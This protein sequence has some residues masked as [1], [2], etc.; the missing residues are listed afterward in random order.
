MINDRY[1][2]DIAHIIYFKSFIYFLENKNPQTQVF[3]G[4]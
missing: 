3:E 1:S 2:V 4:F